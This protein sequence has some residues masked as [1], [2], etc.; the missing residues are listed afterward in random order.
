MSKDGIVNLLKRIESLNRTASIMRIVEPFASKLQAASTVTLPVIFNIFEERYISKDYVELMEIS[1]TIDMSLT[2]DQV[3]L[4]EE[5]T[6]GQHASN[7]WYLQRAGRIT[8][9][10]LKS[11]C[12]TYKESPSLSLI[13]DICYPAK[14]LFRTKAI[15][16]GL[17]H[18]SVAVG[19]YK[20]TM[21]ENHEDFI[22]NEVGLV[23]NTFEV[24][25]IRSISR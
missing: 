17:E 13:K 7:N 21:E 22:I 3:S 4:I 10:K 25:T 8:A 5:N 12:R 20:K 1:K 24:A 15:N 6:H 9:S 18:E 23:P 16:W 19:V 14:A 11:V 2:T